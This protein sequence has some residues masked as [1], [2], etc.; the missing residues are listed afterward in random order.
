MRIKKARIQNYKSIIDSGEISFDDQI[1]SFIGKNEQGK[2]N[3]L[4]SLTTIDKNYTY[5]QQDIYYNIRGPYEQEPIVKRRR[6]TPL[7][8]DGASKAPPHENGTR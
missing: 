3:F 7:Q 5:K 6:R 4:K 1:T 2:T 8:A